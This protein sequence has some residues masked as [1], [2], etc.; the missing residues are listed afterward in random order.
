MKKAITIIP[1]KEIQLEH[2]DKVKIYG[3]KHKIRFNFFCDGTGNSFCLTKQ[4][5]M[6]LLK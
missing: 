5:I 2:G 3:N 6:E 1:D 4:E